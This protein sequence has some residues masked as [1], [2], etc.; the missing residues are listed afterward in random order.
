MRPVRLELDGFA[1][2]R[3]ATVVDFEGA[4]YFALVGPTGSGKSTVID[5]LVFALYGSAPRWG[6]AGS[7]Q[8]VLAPS[9]TRATVRLVFDSGSDRFQVAREV[10]R[11]GAQ[12]QQKS[13]SLERFNDPASGTATTDEVEVLASEVRE[14]TPAVE[15]LLGLSFDDFTKAVVLPQGRFAEFLS[16]TAGERQDILLKLLGAQQYDLVKRAAGQRKALAEQRFQNANAVLDELADAVPQAVADAQRRAARLTSARAMAKQLVAGLATSREHARAASIRLESRQR[17]LDSLSAVQVPEGAETAQQ[18]TRELHDATAA[19]RD[20]DAA[21]ATLHEQS[22]TALDAAGDKS[23]LQRLC[24]AWIERDRLDAELPVLESTQQ[25]AAAA[26][27][28]ATTT[29]ANAETAWLQAGERVPQ[30]QQASQDA[31]RAVSDLTARRA[32]VESV[33]VP[34]E[35]VDLTARLADSAQRTGDSERTILDALHTAELE[36]TRAVSALGV[37]EAGLS[38]LRSRLESGEVSLLE[39]EAPVTSSLSRVSDAFT[40]SVTARDAAAAARRAHDATQQR[41]RALA[42]ETTRAWEDLHQTR[43]AVVPFGAPASPT[44]SLNDAWDELAGWAAAELATLDSTGLPTATEQALRAESDLDAARELADQG[45]MSHRRA[46]AT[47]AAAKEAD[48]RAR[49]ALEQAE[50]TRREL[51]VTLADA[52]PADAL[53]ERLSALQNLEAAE[54]SAY[55]ERAAAAVRLRDATRREAEFLSGLDVAFGELRATRDD[56]VALGAPALDGLDLHSAWQQLADWAQSASVAASAALLDARREVSSAEATV[57]EAERHILDLAAQNALALSTVDDVDAVLAAAEAEAKRDH[58]DLSARLQRRT[59]T[60][61]AR[62][63][64]AEEA[65]VAGLL[66][67]HLNARKFQ[68]WL[69]SAALDVLVDAASD[70]LFEL[71]GQQFGLSHDNGEFFVIDYADAEARRSVRTLSGGETF[72]ASLALALALSAELSSLSSSAARLDSIFLDEGFGSLD[73]DSLEVV[74]STLERLAHGDRM[75]G[76]VTHVQSLAERVPTR[77]RVSRTIRTSTVE[78]EG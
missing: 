27:K 58:D 15:T 74:A 30:A 57:H 10:R 8:Y 46:A 69:A 23:E 31:A 55:K 6:R 45:K 53:A 43:I 56:L 18:R 1:S 73:P 52:D 66:A 49:T 68:R 63:T 34:A 3:A 62:D 64:A 44:T 25:Q 13:A 70:S 38:E 9:A 42:D 19:A 65:A 60:S 59:Q 11:V 78:R 24:Q 5:A 71:S 36:G 28:T 32:V 26:V 17:D 75:V 14:V 33:S 76:I 20:A 12:I 67:D 40:A 61:A 2:F 72:Q 16:A 21:A 41:Q 47:L 54:K 35:I 77:F 39:V 48:I 29:Q 7:V 37:A 51:E 50:T 22:R 4:D